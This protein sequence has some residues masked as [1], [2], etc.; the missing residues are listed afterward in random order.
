MKILAILLLLAAPVLAHAIDIH[1]GD[2]LADVQ[3]TLGPPR[4]QAQLS[5]RLV[6]FYDRGQVQLVDGRVIS[7]D[8]LSPEDFSALQAQRTADNARATQ[9]RVQRITEGQ[10]LKAR[11]LA[12][13]NFASA[14]P[15]YQL[16]F[17]QDFRLRYPE[18]PCNDEYNLA[19]ARQQEHEQEVADLE[20]RVAD[21]E[22]R[23][24]LAERDARLARY[25]TSVFS[26]FFFGDVRRDRFRER[27]ICEHEPK[28][29]DRD[30][31][32]HRTTAPATSPSFVPCNQNPLPTFLIP[33]VQSLNLPTTR[34]TSSS[35]PNQQ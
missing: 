18:V 22:D 20:A 11:K 1:P 9:L 26:P 33:T 21:A 8:F 3:S 32:G 28:N 19:L 31:R 29:N 25:D 6:L 13:P 10:A 30:D 5:D 12:D 16:S 14:P 23:A 2:S 7:L 17:W 34:M 4:G 35:N 24:A 27:E 15:A